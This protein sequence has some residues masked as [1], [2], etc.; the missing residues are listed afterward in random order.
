MKLFK[1][2]DN[3]LLIE[4]SIKFIAVLTVL[5]A[6]YLA[7]RFSGQPLL[8]LFGFRQ[9]Q[10][11]LTSFWFI[12]EGF[13]FAY[14]TPVS[15]APWSIPFEFPLYQ[16][17]VALISK[18]TGIDLGKVGRIVSFVFLVLCL[19]P[20]RSICLSLK[21]APRT[22]YIFA[23]LLFSSPLYLFW[24]RTF[25]IETVAV[26]FAVAAIKYFLDFLAAGRHRDAI[27]FTTLISLSILQKATTG[28]PV[29]A[30]MA[31]VF[32]VH[33]TQRNGGLFKAISAR[34]ITLG[35]QL[36]ALPIVFGVAWTHYTDVLKNQNEFG[37]ALTSSALSTWNWGT[38]PQRFSKLLY[39]EVIWSRIVKGNLSGVFGIAIILCALL[40]ARDTRTRLVV[41]TSCVLALLPLFIFTNL[42]LVH[43]YYQSA[44]VIFI[45][46]ALAVALSQG[47]AHP[48]SRLWILGLFV[49][50]LANN[51]STFAQGY[52]ENLR[53]KIDLSNSKDLLVADTLKHNMK[54]GEAFTLYGNDWSSS[55]VY[56]AQHK[57]FTI[58]NSFKNLD[59]TI[60]SPETF[61]GGAPLGAVVACPPV[62]KPSLGQLVNQQHKDGQWKVAE[63]SGC[64]ISLPQ[65]NAGLDLPKA[66]AQ[67][68]GSLDFANPTTQTLAGAIEVKG[69]TVVDVDRNQLPSQVYIILTDAH[70]NVRY[71]D[72]AQYA[73][74]DV[75]DFFKKSDLG[76]A[77]FG[78]VIDTRDL[79]GSYAVGVARVVGKELQLC[80]FRKDIQV[81]PQ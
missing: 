42:H 21:L 40:M 46:F 79:K 28:L 31:L 30:V 52:G 43:S 66:S 48:Q 32:L 27:Y 75:N 2:A 67:C 25:M 69:W 24:G 65:T 20:A 9:T 5:Y 4:R 1:L 76:N 37:S 64:Y 44:S 70:K 63:V 3:E 54:D 8:E 33:E 17:L 19:L 6:T 53:Q 50:L 35:I 41:L 23:G 49:A 56:Y 58:A 22:F 73:R 36:F 13:K 51:Y 59:K 38:L 18:F 78:R 55:I 74:P 10:T 57:S 81:D 60:E 11:A 26:F 45:I 61:L 12:K 14:E 16:A 62:E 34:N 77:G 72:A 39:G 47:L 29:L 80:Q 71:Y 7:F 15:G 68:I